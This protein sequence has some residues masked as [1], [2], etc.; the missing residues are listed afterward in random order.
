[1]PDETPDRRIFR[2]SRAAGRMGQPQGTRKRPLSDGELLAEIGRELRAVY[3]DLLREPVPERLATI[4]E[5]L[6]RRGRDPDRSTPS[7]GDRHGTR[8]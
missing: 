1:M 6:E 5:R 8:G 4:I 7:R 2:A 3:N